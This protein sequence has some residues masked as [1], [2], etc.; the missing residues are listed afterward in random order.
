MRDDAASKIGRVIVVC[1]GENGSRELGLQ[2]ERLPEPDAEPPGA[3]SRRVIPRLAHARSS[4]LE[5]M[6][7]PLSK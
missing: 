6:A 3:G 7:E 1:A 2:R 5:T 4:C